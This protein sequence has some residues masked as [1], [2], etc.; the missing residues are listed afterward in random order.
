MGERER[1]A[2]M[3]FRREEIVRNQGSILNTLLGGAEVSFHFAF[4]PCNFA[5]TPPVNQKFEKFFVP[6]PS[7]NLMAFTR[8]AGFGSCSLFPG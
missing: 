8:W 5:H 6:A 2:K 4:R 3:N 7:V 1:K